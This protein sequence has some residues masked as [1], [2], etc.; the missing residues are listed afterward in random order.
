MFMANFS[1]T[2]LTKKKVICATKLSCSPEIDVFELVLGALK[3]QRNANTIQHPLPS[4]FSWLL[5][6]IF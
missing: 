1:E 3:F 4:L 5:I 6:H 2:Q